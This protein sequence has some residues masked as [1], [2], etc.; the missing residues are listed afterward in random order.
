MSDPSQISIHSPH[1]RGDQRRSRG[2]ADGAG[3]SIRS[4]HARGDG[5]KRCKR[6]S[7]QISIHSPHTRGDVCWGTNC[8]KRFNFNPLPSCEG[9]PYVNTA[10]PD[11]DQF[12]STPLMR[13]ETR[14]APNLA[15]ARSNFNPLPSCEGRLSKSSLSSAR[16]ISI[17]S[18]H[19]RGDFSGQFLFPPDRFQST[20]LMRGET[21]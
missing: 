19:A 20:P 1:A 18:P 8:R 13:G 11:H 16:S 14:A 15:S 4:P 12:Q 9:R 2:H 21:A 6:C 17:H 10:D 7:I 3:I 5:R